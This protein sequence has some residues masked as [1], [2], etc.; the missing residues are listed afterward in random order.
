MTL[1]SPT[2]IETW[3]KNRMG[4]RELSLDRLSAFQLEHLNRTLAHVWENSP[5]YRR[6]LKETRGAPLTGLDRITDLPFTTA[7]DIRQHHLDMLCVSHSD[8]ARVV[9]LQTS[10]TSSDPKRLY[11][12]GKDID[13][14]IDFFHY[15]MTSLVEPG[16]HVL[17]M[18]PGM[19][20]HSVADQLKR[21]IER[22][23]ATG[24]IHWPVLN[25][26]SILQEIRDK[27]ISCLAG[28]PSQ[29]LALCRHDAHAR[30]L[31]PHFIKSILLSTDYIPRVVVDELK[32]VWGC[33]VFEHY[34][35]TEMGLG[36]ALEC[37]AHQ[38]YHLREADLLV[39]VIDPETNAP[40]PAGIPGEV[41]FTTLT[42]Q[43]M[44]LIR[45]RTGDQAFWIKEIC[46]CG[47]PLRRLGKVGGR[48]T[49]LYS[50]RTPL[51]MPDLDEAILALP[52]V[53][54]F[55]AACTSEKDGPVMDLTV[56]CIPERSGAL[57]DEVQKAITPL[58]KKRTGT[59]PSIHIHTSPPESLRW[60]STG[61]IKRTIG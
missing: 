47:S 14:T 56:F 50:A 15:G 37:D 12:S 61:M 13:S 41:I 23:P 9:T 2:R 26:D 51:S 32:R 1:L 48:L 6:H 42:R 60:D 52:G 4:T 54:S 45:Y 57:K 35:M 7:R 58:F 34:G 31:P 46:P 55:Q 20:P 44:P 28:V 18:F 11:F 43:A 19:T 25:L 49:D 22:I 36:A 8:V 40:V 59:M 38:G 10:G 17:I 27:Q 30:F 53:Y 21:A 5:F 24:Y 39:E 33:T 29:I 3:L 16:Q